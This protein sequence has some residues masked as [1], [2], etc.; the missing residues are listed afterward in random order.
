MPITLLI[1][2]DHELVRHGLRCTFART[3]VEVVAEAATPAEARRAAADPAVD[4]MLLDVRWRQGEGASLDGFDLLA[5]IRASRTR[6]AVLMYSICGRADYVERCRCLGAAGYLVKG[7]DD[8]RLLAAV[9]AAHAGRQ[10]W[11]GARIP[12]VS[13]AGRGRR[14]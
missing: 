3:D 4:V 12:N 13:A 9:R 6:L 5:E 2:D 7:V 8:R 11:P 1:A 14:K 10:V